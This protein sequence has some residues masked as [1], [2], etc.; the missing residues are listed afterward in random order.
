MMHIVSTLLLNF[1]EEAHTTEY[2]KGF[3]RTPGKRV[4]GVKNIKSKKR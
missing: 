3:L 4:P 1:D 2:L